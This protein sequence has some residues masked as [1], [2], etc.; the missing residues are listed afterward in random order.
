VTG[1][2]SLHSLSLTEEV[3]SRQLL[4]SLHGNAKQ[5]AVHH[6]WASKDLIPVMLPAASVLGIEFGLYL[7]DLALDFPVVLRYAIR[8]GDG[9][10][11]TSHTA[12]AILL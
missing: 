9:G 2:S 6:A 3:G 1:R 11:S 8:L 10:T 7:A 4:Q 12:L 5:R